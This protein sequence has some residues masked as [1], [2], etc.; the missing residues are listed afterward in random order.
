[1][2]N[3]ETYVTTVRL[4]IQYNHTTGNTNLSPHKYFINNI[5][6]SGRMT[7]T[8]YVPCPKRDF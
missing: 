6:I 8:I 3:A 2:M 7:N 5:L 1:M 4:I